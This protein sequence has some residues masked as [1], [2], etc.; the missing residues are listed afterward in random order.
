MD[1]QTYRNRGYEWDDRNRLARY[2]SWEGEV[3]E[4][5]MQGFTLVPPQYYVPG[6]RTAERMAGTLP[7]MYI[8]RNDGPDKLSA[9]LDCFAC[10]V[11]YPLYFKTPTK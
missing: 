2:A 8:H 6:W 11:R 9:H 3:Q 4:M 5:A 10:S 7:V 1:D